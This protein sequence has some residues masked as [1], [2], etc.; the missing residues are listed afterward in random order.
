MSD[1]QITIE[2]FIAMPPWEREFERRFGN[3]SFPP[4]EEL[5]PPPTNEPLVYFIQQGEHGYIKIGMAGDPKKRLQSLQTS[6][7][8]PLR[9]LA[10]VEGGRQQEMIYHARFGD[11]RVRGE[12]FRPCNAILREINRIKKD[13]Q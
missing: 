5:P 13:H 10:V 12:W 9:L 1:T 11:N 6:N 7:P 3:A 2:E 4:D 8:E